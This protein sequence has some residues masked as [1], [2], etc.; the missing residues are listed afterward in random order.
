MT[1]NV[2]R[3]RG[4]DGV[5]DPLRVA[6]VIAEAAPDIVA[7]QDLSPENGKQLATLAE[8]LGMRAYDGE[9][10]G[11]NAFLSYYPLRG[12]QAYALGSGASCLRADA[13]IL[14]KRVHLFNLRL[15]CDWSKRPGQVTTLLGP[16]VLGNPVLG[17][18]LLLLGDF[19]DGIW[20]PGNL[21][22][23]LGLR[24]APRPFLHGTF[25]ARL[26]LLGRDR[27]YLRGELRILATNVHRS[28]LA[29]RAANHLPLLLTVQ[30]CDPRTYLHLP[31]KLAG[32]MEIAPG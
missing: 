16:E 19:A 31:A 21:G 30:V 7:L 17:C 6:A 22:L 28:H 3:C 8:S 13:D 27:A 26:P 1:Y 32:R 11:G 18:P 14:R 12:T 4:R 2:G 15:D 5:S 9:S 25:P 24:Q 23:S 10:R 29:R 20:G